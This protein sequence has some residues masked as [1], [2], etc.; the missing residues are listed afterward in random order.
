VKRH[1]LHEDGVA[2]A[3]PPQPHPGARA[4]CTFELPEF[5]SM[6]LINLS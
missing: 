5:K 3:L 1:A 6:R 4:A 2:G